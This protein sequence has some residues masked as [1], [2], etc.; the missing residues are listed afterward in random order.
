VADMSNNFVVEIIDLSQNNKNNK[1]TQL[2]K[3]RI[4]CCPN[5]IF[6]HP[7]TEY[8]IE[9]VTDSLKCML[10]AGYDEIPE[11]LVKKCINYVKNH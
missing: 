3:Q 9:C 10:S 6:L 8:E 2:Q 5:T 7:V 11:F 1:N 4:N